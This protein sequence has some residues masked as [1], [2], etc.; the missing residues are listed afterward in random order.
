MIDWSARSYTLEP[1][2]GSAMLDT[3]DEDMVQREAE[4]DWKVDA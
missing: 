3:W 4:D 2:P 1:R